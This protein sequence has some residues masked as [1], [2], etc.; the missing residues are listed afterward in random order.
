MSAANSCSHKFWSFKRHKKVTRMQYQPSTFNYNWDID[1]FLY[2]CMSAANI[3]VVRMGTVSV[4]VSRKTF[5]FAL[6]LIFF[7]LNQNTEMG[8]QPQVLAATNFDH[9]RGIKSD[10]YAISALHNW[11]IDVF[12]YACMSAANLHAVRMGTVFV[13]VSRKTFF[14]LHYVGI[15]FKLNQNTEMGCQPQIL[16]ATNFDHLRGIKSDTYAISALHIQLQLRYWCFSV[17]VYVSRKYL[18][19]SNGHSFCSRKPQNLFFFASE[20]I[21]LLVNHNTKIFWQPQILGAANFVR[22]RHTRFVTF[23]G[24][25]FDYAHF[26][27]LNNEYTFFL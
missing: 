13:H 20:R 24:V 15:F 2:A 9:L 21:L 19:S 7:K 10:T 17:C 6:C 14:V 3:Y 16:A 22:L 23:W 11:D 4:H 5:F 1:V 12:L 8:C 26:S 18:R 27:M 25:I